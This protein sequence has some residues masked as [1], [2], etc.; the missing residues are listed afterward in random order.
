MSANDKVKE[1]LDYFLA[2]N[3]EADF[4]IM[5]N[6]PWGAGKTHFIK[7]YFKERED[8]AA[9]GDPFGHLYASLYGVRS[10]SEITGQFFAQAHP[11]L[12]SKSVRLLGSVAS[13][14]LDGFVGTQVS[15]GAE[16]KSFI[17]DMALKLENRVLIFDDLERCAM[18]LADVMGFINSYVEHDGLKV[19][20]IANEDDIP[21]G[22]KSNYLRKKEKL[23]GKTLRVTSE[24]EVVL[25]SFVTKLTKQ[26]VIDT[27]NRERDPLLRA[28]EASQGQNFRSLKFVLSDFERLVTAC[29]SCLQKAPQAMTKLMLFMMAAGLEYRS[30]ELTAGEIANLPE[31]MRSRMISLVAKKEKTPAVIKVERL[32]STYSGVVWED[33]IIPP[34]T[35][36]KLFETGIVD[37]VSINAHLAKHPLVVGYAD[38]P[39]WRQLWNWTDLPRE[40]Y[41]VA[42]KQLIDELGSGELTHPGEILHAAGVVIRLASYDDHLLG[43]D[44]VVTFFERYVEALRTAGRLDPARDLFSSSG[45]SYVG[46]GY[47]SDSPEFRKIYAVARAAA[48]A[49][50][51][52]WMRKV[53]LT[54]IDRIENNP[55][56]Y[57]SLREHGVEQGN[58]GD[59]PFLHYIDP[60]DFACVITR[61]SLPDGRLLANLHAR[62][63]FEPLRHALAEE[64]TWLRT[65]RP[66]LEA[67]AAKANAP[68]KRLLEQE[69][70][71]YFDK[72]EEA[73]QAAEASAAAPDE[74]IEK[75]LM[76]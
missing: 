15:P 5:L 32:E 10:I 46:L 27:I 76:G 68:H 22:Q 55:N 74:A 14:V 36:A 34:A 12:S 16:D 9:R 39:A 8:K 29:D 33:P 38:T 41:L 63:E 62:Y 57:S 20:V 64:Y 26:A 67:S 11:V 58:Y 44:D 4:A 6:G 66:R 45:R 56:A 3:L 65:L 35:L 37:T 18:P 70:K 69:I 24:P 48:N 23:I 42:R 51:A 7:N 73:V 61:D 72:I 40:Q 2:P 21:E 71:H 47:S 53:S 13:R 54:Y 50:F 60:D 59:A 31:T 52:D 28:F 17:Q 19:I 49:S 30:G 43:D 25:R 1:Y 75:Q